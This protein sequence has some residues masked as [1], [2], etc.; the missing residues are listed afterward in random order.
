MTYFQQTIIPPTGG[1]VLNVLGDRLTIKLDGQDTA[2]QLALME[3]EV[4]AGNGVPPHHHK[5]FSEAYYLLEGELEVMVGDETHIVGPGTLV[6]VP[7]G[8][9]HRYRNPGNTPAR[10]IMWAFPSGIEQF[11]RT[12]SEAMTTDNFS[13]DQ[14][15]VIAAQHDVQLALSIPG[16][17]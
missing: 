2:D 8:T 6:Q 16:G 13:P 12:L 11:F 1:Q 15:G 3:L 9:I 7:R 17:L 5:N 14:V 10:V 4:S